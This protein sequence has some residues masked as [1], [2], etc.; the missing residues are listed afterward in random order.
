MPVRI[1][2]L[3]VSLL[4]IAAPAFAADANHDIKG[5]YLLTDYPAVTV[6]P[7]TTS[8][9]N[10]KLRN[11]ALAPERLALSVAGVPQGWTATLLGGGQPIA[12]AMP[13][14]DDSVSLDLRLDVPKDAKIGSHTLTVNADGTDNHIALPVAVTLA[15]ELPAKMTLAPQLP[16]LR[17]SSRSSFE[18]TLTIKNDSGKKLLVSLAADAP[19]NFDTSF[20]EAYGTPAAH[21][22]PG[23]GRQEKD[24]KLKVQPARH[25]RCRRYNVCDSAHRRRR[26]ARRLPELR[27]TLPA[28]PSS[29]SPAGEGLLSARATAGKDSRCRWW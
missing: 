28:S 7:G 1:L 27:S 13:A 4:A 25:R 6:Q 3:I 9:V 24:V 19:K 11:Y 8:T 22:D 10:L 2:A 18:Y 5:L 21:R 15:K 29:R 17:G 16:E 26:C 20:T 23:R 14:T 12:A